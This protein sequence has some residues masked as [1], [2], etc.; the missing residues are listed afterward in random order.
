MKIKKTQGTEQNVDD[1]RY[2]EP[3]PELKQY[4]KSAR[5]N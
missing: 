4:R 5:R 3:K 2:S 1:M